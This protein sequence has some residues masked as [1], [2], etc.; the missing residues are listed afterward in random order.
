M[1]KS[2]II[3]PAMAVIAFSTAASIAGSVAWFTASRTVTISGG[4]YSVVKVTSNLDATL[5]NGV[6]TSVTGKQVT[7]TGKLTDASFNHNLTSGK[8]FYI[9]NG[10]EGDAFAF[11][12]SVDLDQDLDDLTDDLERTSITIESTAYTVYSAATFDI[13]FDIDIGAGQPNVAL[14]LDA[15]AS[16]FTVTGTAKTAKGFRMAFIPK[17]ST[18]TENSIGVSK[19]FAKLQTATNC[20]YVTGMSDKTGSAYTGHD[21]M[22]SGYCSS[23]TMPS[24]NVD[25]DDLSGINAYLG[26]AAKPATGH[27]LMT[28]TVVCWFEGTDPEIVNRETDADYQTVSVAL[29]ITGVD[30]VDA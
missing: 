10:L 25:P 13:T 7:F 20:K 24:P 16:S 18:F 1:K 21:L 11:T 30:V 5:A 3:V 8:K 12:K 19:V 17:L 23:F 26:T 2:R 29:S 28:Y 27:A 6:G 9:P 22:D 4:Q 15:S 14:F